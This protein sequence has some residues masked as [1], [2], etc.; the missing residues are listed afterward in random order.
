[1]NVIVLTDQAR[2]LRS[3]I[4]LYLNSEGASTTVGHDFGTNDYSMLR[5]LERSTA[6]LCMEPE[7]A[8]RITDIWRINKVSG[9]DNADDDVEWRDP[10]RHIVRDA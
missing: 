1:M 8:A 4:E 6:D 9:V 2:Y 5:R 7:Y 10:Q 3:C